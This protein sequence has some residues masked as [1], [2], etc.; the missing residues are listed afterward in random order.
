LSPSEKE[1]VS[2]PKDRLS[3]EYD[4]IVLIKKKNIEK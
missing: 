3:K 1:P 4:D 2:P